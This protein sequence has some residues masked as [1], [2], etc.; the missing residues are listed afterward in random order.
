MEWLWAGDGFLSQAVRI[1]IIYFFTL[2]MLRIAG[3][4][5]L[6]HLS[7][8]DILIIIA[9]GSAVGDVMA[10]PESTVPLTDGL[11]VVFMV[12]FLQIAIIKV[13]E[14]H[15]GLSYIVH[16]KGAELIRRGRIVHHNLE[17]EDI[18]EEELYEL[19]REKGVDEVSDVK[20]AVLERSGELGVI[21]IKKSERHG[22]FRKVRG[23]F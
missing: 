8:F 2:L 6:A 19:L 3:K 11:M 14:H 16:G 9:L 4:R 12:I 13:T 18:T 1:L 15:K 17:A 22:K 7:G 5:R 10:Y 20:E 21:L 23:L